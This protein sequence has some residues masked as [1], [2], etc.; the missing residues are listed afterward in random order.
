[1][2]STIS[3]ESKS[4]NSRINQKKLF[5]WDHSPIDTSRTLVRGDSH[6]VMIDETSRNSDLKVVGSERYRLSLDSM[7]RSRRTREILEYLGRL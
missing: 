7:V 6:V 3:L 1:M 5:C 2:V 4:S